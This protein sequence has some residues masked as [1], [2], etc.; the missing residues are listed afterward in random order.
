MD[1]AVHRGFDLQCIGFNSSFFCSLPNQT[2]PG[3]QYR[4]QDGDNSN[5]NHQLNQGETALTF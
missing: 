1:H 4:C 5:N 2:R 3:N